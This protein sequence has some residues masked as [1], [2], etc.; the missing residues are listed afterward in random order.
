MKKYLLTVFLA[1]GTIHADYIW[2]NGKLIDFEKKPWMP[3]QD[4]YTEVL[5]AHDSKKWLELIE[6]GVVLIHH[7]KNSPFVDETRFLLAKAF[8]EINDYSR[9]HDALGQYL[10]Y[11]VS[12]KH[13]EEVMQMK[14]SLA[15]AFEN[16]EIK[17]LIGLPGIPH[18]VDA[19]KEAVEL[20]DEI[21]SAMPTHL[22]AEQAIMGKAGLEIKLKDYRI[23]I[24]TCEAFL[25][26]YAKSSLAPQAFENIGFCQLKL[27]QDEFLDPDILSLAEMNFRKFSDLY[28]SHPKLETMRSQLIEM[29]ELF[30]SN[31]L[32]TAKYYRKVKKETA[33]QFYF[34]KIQEN[35]PGTKSADLAALLVDP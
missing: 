10:N 24:S 14:L 30:A 23:A 13:Y 22:L 12:P 26:K 1:L 17:N 20:Y 6:N 11:S 3:M 8:L 34:K 21:A 28:P 5:K 7:Y 9:A 16:G 33:A 18:W 25:R 4:H 31:M 2:K 19:R 15:Q 29:K 27:I 32:T 35:Y